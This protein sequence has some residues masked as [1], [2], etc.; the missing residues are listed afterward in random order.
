M[1]NTTVLPGAVGGGY[2]INRKLR[3]QVV[4]ICA[5]VR[6]V[7]VYFPLHAH[8]SVRYDSANANTVRCQLQ[9]AYNL[10]ADAVGG[11]VNEP[12]G[13]A[14]RFKENVKTRPALFEE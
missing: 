13:A 1:G 7:C 3:I 9:G 10:M 2:R 8:I 11:E 6:G 12:A 14:D 5:T 4:E